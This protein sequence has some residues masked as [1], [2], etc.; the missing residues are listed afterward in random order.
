[1]GLGR[2][3]GE[4][5]RLWKEKEYKEVRTSE[6]QRGRKGL[7]SLTKGSH[8]QPRS[9]AYLLAVFPIAAKILWTRESW[10]I[11][12]NSMYRYKIDG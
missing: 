5:G 2:G 4:H 8:S 1:M 11:L 6:P 10:T 3:Q 7:Y 12:R 9:P